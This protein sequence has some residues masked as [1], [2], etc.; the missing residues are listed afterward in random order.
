MFYRIYDT[1]LYFDIF[2]RFLAEVKGIQRR[3]AKYE[4]GFI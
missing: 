3:R 1:M 2:N 4:V